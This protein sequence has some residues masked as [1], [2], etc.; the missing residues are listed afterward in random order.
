MTTTF[1]E[2]KLRELEKAFSFSYPEK[3]IALAKDFES[4]RT[5]FDKIFKSYM[6]VDDLYLDWSILN[7]DKLEL[8]DILTTYDFYK[9]TGLIPFLIDFL[10]QDVICFEKSGSGNPS[11]CAFSV[12]SQVY[13]WKDFDD[14]LRWMDVKNTIE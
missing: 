3:Y 1:E 9:S 14:F 12:D 13:T 6:F 10:N 2:S 5:K 7:L 4:H 8:L 11:V